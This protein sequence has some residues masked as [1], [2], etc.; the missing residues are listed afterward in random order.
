M[1]KPETTTDAGADG[2]PVSPGAHGL[3]SSERLSR[4][5]EDVLRS[6]RENHMW[7]NAFATI[8]PSDELK[9]TIGAWVLEKLSDPG[10]TIQADY[11]D[12]EI[13][14]ELNQPEVVLRFNRS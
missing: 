7:V 2:A 8:R 12:S 4:Y 6:A 1:G 3:S 10:S 11:D 9:R 13:L 5:E 14:R